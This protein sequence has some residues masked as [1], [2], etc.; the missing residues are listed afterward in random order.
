MI[1]SWRRRKNKKSSGS[2]VKMPLEIQRSHTGNIIIII[3]IIHQPKHPS[4][5]HD[6]QIKSKHNATLFR[7]QSVLQSFPDER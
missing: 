6:S 4:C 2:V 3:I 5:M 7:M 1:E